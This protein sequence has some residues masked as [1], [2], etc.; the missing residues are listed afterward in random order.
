MSNG[1]F[2]WRFRSGAGRFHQWHRPVFSVSWPVG[3]AACADVP[4]GVFVSPP[5][6]K[7]QGEA[8]EGEQAG[9]EGGVLAGVSGFD[10]EAS[11]PC[12]ERVAEV[13]RDL[14]TGGSEHFTPF[15][16]ADQKE[17]LGGG[18]GEETRGADDHQQY[19]HDWAFCQKEY[20]K[21]C[22]AHD[23]LRGGGDFAGAEPVGQA[24]TGQVADEHAKSCQHHQVHHV[25]GIESRNGGHEWIDVTQPAEGATVSQCGGKQD[26][27]GNRVFQETELSGKTGVGQRGH[28]RY[29]AP[30]QINEDDRPATDQKESETP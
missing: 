14:D 12:T 20:G 19:R 7:E 3:E 8:D 28:H 21:K 5:E 15:G 2:S 6:V 11:C 13:E 17:L 1:L 26:E 4:D 27:P 9:G 10:G 16:M 30:E 23:P 24:P 29:P 18:N 25:G 22:H